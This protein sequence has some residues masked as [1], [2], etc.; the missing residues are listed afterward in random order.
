MASSS[1]FG[2]K[3]LEIGPVRGGGNKFGDGLLEKMLCLDSTHER[4]SPS[5]AHDHLEPSQW[6]I[7]LI[8]EA[9]DATSQKYLGK[10]KRG[11][12]AQE[13]SDSEDDSPPKKRKGGGQSLEG[14]MALL[15]G[16]RDRFRNKDKNQD[17]PFRA[18]EWLGCAF[19][20][21][22]TKSKILDY[23][24]VVADM[25]TCLEYTVEKVRDI[26]NDGNSQKLIE[27]W[28][29]QIAI[30]DTVDYHRNDDIPDILLA[31]FPSQIASSSK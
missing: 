29:R 17:L 28:N 16:P 21:P 24:F 15:L 9:F 11:D 13:D 3:D 27:V 22:P 1:V 6:E 25:S 19:V 20:T 23:D 7:S 30:I 4:I 8:H 2:G 31:V 12:S 14:I 26:G 5:D 10:C 18:I